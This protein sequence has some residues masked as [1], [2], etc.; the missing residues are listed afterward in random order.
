MIKLWVCRH[1]NIPYGGDDHFCR[2]HQTTIAIHSDAERFHSARELARIPCSRATAIETAPR[3][4]TIRQNPIPKQTDSIFKGFNV[5]WFWWLYFFLIF[6]I[7][8]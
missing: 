4:Q 6:E 2:V 1:E 7:K 3:P 5:R 8:M